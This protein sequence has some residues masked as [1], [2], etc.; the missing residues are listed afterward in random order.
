MIDALPGEQIGVGGRL[1]RDE[2][3]GRTVA[4]VNGAIGDNLLADIAGVAKPVPL[5]HEM[6]ITARRMGISLG[7]KGE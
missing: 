3:Y 1:I 2:N 5:D 6:V 7:D 4:L